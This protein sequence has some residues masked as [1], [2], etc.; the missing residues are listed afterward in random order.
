LTLA[1]DTQGHLTAPPP[2]RPPN[3]D[4][5]TVTRGT[6]LL[7]LYRPDRHSTTEL[8]FRFF[9]PLRRF[10]H[11]RG[12]GAGKDPG[13]DLERGVWYGGLSLSVCIV[14]I[15]GDS[16]LVALDPWRLATPVLARDVV[17]LDIRGASSMH[18]GATAE[19]AKTADARLSQS[20]SRYFYDNVD[21]YGALDGL[22]YGS[23]HNDED[24][25]VLNERAANSLVCPSSCSVPLRDSTLTDEL[26]RICD[27]YGFD[28]ES[29][30]GW[31]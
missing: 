3:P 15:F 24:C 21:I 7:R 11:H 1:S 19:L 20:W 10:D 17:L 18:A 29:P 26:L 23:A 8:S 6:S 22:I 30:L 4:P 25:V 28:V 16:G 14:E 9:G 13:N 12:V 5:V 2:A 31:P 27:D